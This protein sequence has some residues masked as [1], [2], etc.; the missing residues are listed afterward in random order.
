M[1]LCGKIHWSIILGPLSIIWNSWVLL[2]SWN[3]FLTFTS[4]TP[5]LEGGCWFLLVLP[6]SKMLSASWLSHGNSFLFYIHSLE[7]YLISWFPI[8]S[9]CCQFLDIVLE[10]LSSCC[11]LRISSCL[12][13]VFARMSRRILTCSKPN[14]GSS[15]HPQTCSFCT[16]I[17]H[18]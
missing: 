5:L 8:L 2:S 6:N 10:S 3:T 18:K 9:I 1:P 12:L 7:G 16:P 17:S 14:S 4:R 15:S 13:N 11:T